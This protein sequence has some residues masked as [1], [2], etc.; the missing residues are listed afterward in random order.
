MSEIRLANNKGMVIV[1]ASDYEWLSEFRWY[2]NG[3][4]ACAAIGGKTVR[5]HRLIMGVEGNA[6]VDHKNRHGLDNRRANLR[7]ATRSQN[8]GNQ[9]SHKGSRSKY[10]GVYF[11]RTR[12]KWR[13]MIIVNGKN[14]HLGYFPDEDSAAERYNEEAP[15]VFGEFA[16]LNIV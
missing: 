14:K 4:Y 7:I 13:A 3:P 1:D 12:G 10:K 2:L 6:L 8:G 16:R 15:R 5:M 9:V 11:D